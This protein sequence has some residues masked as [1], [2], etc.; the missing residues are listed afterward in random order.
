MYIAPDDVEEE[1]ERPIDNGD[2]D[3]T[4]TADEESEAETIPYNFDI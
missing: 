4:I 3:R 1:E 2:S